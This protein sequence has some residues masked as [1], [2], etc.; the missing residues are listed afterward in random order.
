[1]FDGGDQE[2]AIAASYFKQAEEFTDRWPRTAEFLREL[3]ESYEREGRRMDEEAER[4][5]KGWRQLTSASRGLY[6]GPRACSR[7][8]QEE[9]G[10]TLGQREERRFPLFRKKI[11][12]A[13]SFALAERHHQSC[14]RLRWNIRSRR[15]KRRGARLIPA[16][17]RLFRCIRFR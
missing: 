9:G 10:E 7:L 6:T 13:Y 16:R 12:L 2:R 14:R 5:R 15:R 8:M 1:M 4:R 17:L 11:G 3:S